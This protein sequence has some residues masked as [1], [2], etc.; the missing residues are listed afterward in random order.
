MKHL[1]KKLLVIVALGT[2][3]AVPAFAQQAPNA[4]QEAPWRA[5]LITMSLVSRL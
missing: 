3:L 5:G 1:M 4:P 2:V